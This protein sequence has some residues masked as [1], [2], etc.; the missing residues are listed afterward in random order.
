[1][2]REEF[3]KELKYKRYSY[4]IVGNKIVVTHKGYVKLNSLETLPPE[5]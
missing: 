1:M 2:T 5:V 4:E 3:I